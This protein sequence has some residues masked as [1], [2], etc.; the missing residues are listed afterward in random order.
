MQ[1]LDL[2]AHI[3]VSQF[4]ANS[5]LGN[6]QKAQPPAQVPGASVLEDVNQMYTLPLPRSKQPMFHI[7]IYLV[8][9]GL[10]YFHVDLL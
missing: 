6:N 9:T 3:W 5:I 1:T 10:C 4:S 2:T 7:H 8:N